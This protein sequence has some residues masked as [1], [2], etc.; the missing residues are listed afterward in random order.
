[1]LML[2]A[3]TAV[4]ERD[5]LR[6]PI[7]LLAS[8]GLLAFPAFVGHGIVIPLVHVLDAQPIP[9]VVALVVPLAAFLII[10]FLAVRKLYSMLF[11]A[12]ARRDGITAE[13]F[14]A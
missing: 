10:A 5:H 8:I 14:G 2:A 1:M 7:R 9:Y 3:M 4:I 6:K 12:S 13:E 11:G